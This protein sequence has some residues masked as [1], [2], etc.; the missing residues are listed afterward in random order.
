MTPR[1]HAMGLYGWDDDAVAIVGGMRA[2]GYHAPGRMRTRF[3]AYD[4]AGAQPRHV[5]DLLLDMELA[6][7]DGEFP[8][9]VSIVSVEVA[10]PLRRNGEGH[11][12][13][14]VRALSEIADADLPVHDIRAG[15]VGFWRKVGCVG[16]EKRLGRTH[17]VLDRAAVLACAPARAPGF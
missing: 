1:H 8:R 16:F 10:K 7:R 3:Q 4:V 6:R 12:A 9:I 17:A 2:D 15:A 13:R 14:I 11:G 5:G